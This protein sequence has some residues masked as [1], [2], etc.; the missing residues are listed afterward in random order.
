MRALVTGAS[1]FIGSSVCRK[2]KAEGHEVR[3]FVR[4]RQKLGDLEKEL[5]DVAIGDITKP[6]TL[7][8][9]TAGCDVVFSIAGTFREPSLSDERYREIN[10]GGTR[11]VL[12]AAKNNGVRRVVHCSTVGIHGNVTGPAIDETAPLVP[13]G[14]YEE[15]KAEGDRL[16][17]DFAREHGLEVV[18]LR[19]SPV[20]GPGDTR[21]LKLF[22]LASKRRVI[23][24][25]DGSA[26]YHLVYIDDLAQA[27]H[28][29]ATRPVAP[30][31]AFLVGGAESPRLIDLIRELGDTMQVLGQKVVHLPAGPVRQL[32]HLCEI[33]CRPMKID[34]PIYR[35]RIDFFINNRNYRIDKAKR[36]LGYAPAIGV[37]KGI[38]RTAHWYQQQG[39]LQPAG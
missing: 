38:A 15:T 18:V 19:P 30:G 6:E 34:P 35:R 20:Y 2:L 24:L 36:L 5:D 25:G 8:A 33:V 17:R 3:A 7:S 27:F 14:I 12:E 9:A 21:L 29:A 37:R 39:L 13:D 22:K 10:V 23:L 16:A 31:E 26:H 1:G 4:S 28:L 32:A 11:N